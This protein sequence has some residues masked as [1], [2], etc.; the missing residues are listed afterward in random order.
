MK[1]CAT[2]SAPALMPTIIPLR[3]PNSSCSPSS[4]GMGGFTRT[5]L[6]STTPQVPLWRSSPRT[7]LAPDSPRLGMNPRP[8]FQRKNWARLGESPHLAFLMA[9]RLRKSLKTYRNSKLRSGGLPDRQP[10]GGRKSAR[11]G[12]RRPGPPGDYTRTP[13]SWAATPVAIGSF[14]NQSSE[15]VNNSVDKPWPGTQ[16]ARMNAKH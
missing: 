1:R 10:H 12:L 3:H 15:P 5:G 11:M 9:D 6:I 4:Y 8:K 7:S 13:G 14:R 2:W 16:K